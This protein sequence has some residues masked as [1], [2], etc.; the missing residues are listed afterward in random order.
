MRRYSDILR[1]RSYYSPGDFGCSRG[2]GS[3]IRRG[4]EL[5]YSHS[6]VRFF[7]ANRRFICLMCR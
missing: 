2:R 1:N 6:A 4:G 5:N 7:V 3:E